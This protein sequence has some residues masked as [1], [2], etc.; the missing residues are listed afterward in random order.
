MD[1][2]NCRGGV[3]RK[4]C[5]APII[6][7]TTENGKKC[8]LDREPE[9]RYVMTLR[10]DWKMVDTYVSHFA[11]CPNAALFREKKT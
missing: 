11:T 10:G 8:P 4:G 5:G 2:A 9:K 1:Y 3:G 6:W 7:I